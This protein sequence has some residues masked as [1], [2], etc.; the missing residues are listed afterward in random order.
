MRDENLQVI[1]ITLTFDLSA[2]DSR[3]MGDWHLT[4]IAPGTS[5]EL[6]DVGMPALLLTH[7]CVDELTTCGDVGEE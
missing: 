1:E 3:E 5:E 2:N 6:L 4:V 7:H